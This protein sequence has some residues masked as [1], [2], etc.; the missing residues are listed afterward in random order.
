L[1]GDRAEERVVRKLRVERSDQRVKRVVTAATADDDTAFVGVGSEDASDREALFQE[2]THLSETGGDVRR[3]KGPPRAVNVM[4]VD[5]RPG[6]NVH[7][8]DLRVDRETIV[9]QGPGFGDGFLRKIG[10][11]K[12][13][14]AVKNVCKVCKVF[15]GRHVREAI[16]R[17][18]R[19]RR[20]TEG[21][22]G[23]RRSEDRGT[24]TE[25]NRRRSGRAHRSR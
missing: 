16:K 18:V 19:R 1:T 14:F 11:L 10:G 23:R 4:G 20:Q 3:E 7:A 2:D 5:R 9:P 17:N 15:W 25:G 8:V 21:D 22:E 24:S 12:E 6:R 13:L